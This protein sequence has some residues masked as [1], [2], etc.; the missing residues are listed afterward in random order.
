VFD[1]LLCGRLYGILHRPAPTRVRPLA[2]RVHTY[3]D[4]PPL[5]K[6]VLRV[7]ARKRL[8]GARAL[9]SRVFVSRVLTQGQRPY[10]ALAI[11][12]VWRGHQ[13]RLEAER[14]GGV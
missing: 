11:Q 12:R 14:W 10:Y 4:V 5:L 13:G 3:S 2:R 1:V 6:V 7:R 9:V 8:E